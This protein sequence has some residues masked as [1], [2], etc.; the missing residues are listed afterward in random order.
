[1]ISTTPEPTHY[2]IAKISKE[3]PIKDLRW[4]LGHVNMVSTETIEWAKR[5][6]WVITVHNG[7]V[8]QATQPWPNVEAIQNSGVPW[9]MGSDGT[10]VATYNPFDTIWQNVAGKIFP[11]IEVYNEDQVISRKD[12]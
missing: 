2:P 7:V 5:L 12:A 11:N 10:I 3:Y 9:G 4:T 8:K 6:G 1:M